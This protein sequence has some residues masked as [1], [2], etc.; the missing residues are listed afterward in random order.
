MTF[1]KTSPDYFAKRIGDRFVTID[2]NGKLTYY[3]NYP[4]LSKHIRVGDYKFSG[5]NHLITD[6]KWAL[7]KN[8]LRTNL[9]VI[10]DSLINNIESASSQS[11]INPS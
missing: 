3:G 5:G 7:T 9:T 6:I 8:E 2:S 11:F 1:D 10:K 4:N